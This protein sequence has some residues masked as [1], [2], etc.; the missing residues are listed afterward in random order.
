MGPMVRADRPIPRQGMFF[1]EVS[2]V[3]VGRNKEVA[4]GICTRT[5]PLHSFPGWDPC[6]FGYHGDDGNIEAMEINIFKFTFT[7]HQV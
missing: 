5:T 3:N 4:V 2:I 1:F 7:V 6:S